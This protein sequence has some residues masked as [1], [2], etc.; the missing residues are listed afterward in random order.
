[1][2]ITRRSFLLLAS[3]QIAHHESESIALNSCGL[4]ACYQF[5]TEG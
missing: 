3:T 2:I 5:C 1:M 4:S